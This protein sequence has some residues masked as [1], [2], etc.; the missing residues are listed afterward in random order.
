MAEA[1]VY[2]YFIVHPGE[3]AAGIR[4]YDETVTVIV[5][6]G[7]PGGEPEEFHEYMRKV[8]A[9]WFDGASVT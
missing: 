6:S 2:S 3:R 1:E 4:S 5:Q 9:E 8:L 7:D